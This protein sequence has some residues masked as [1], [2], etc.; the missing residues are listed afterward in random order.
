MTITDYVCF[1][2]FSQ[3]TTDCSGAPPIPPWPL[4]RATHAHDVIGEK[5]GPIN[6]ELGERGASKAALTGFFLFFFLFVYVRKYPY[7]FPFCFF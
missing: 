4:G 7:V 6:A 1:S 2:I 3:R 5:A